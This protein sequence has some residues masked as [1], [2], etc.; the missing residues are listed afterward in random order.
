[1]IY[2]KTQSA[3]EAK[4]LLSLALK[5]MKRK[6]IRLL[7]AGCG[8]NW[9]KKNAPKTVKVTGLDINNLSA[10][11]QADLEK[12]LPIKNE[13]Y[14]VIICTSVIE[15]LKNPI[16]TFKEF[17]RIL[18]KEGILLIT[19]PSPWDICAWDDPYHYKPYTLNAWEMLG[20]DATLKKVEG[21]YINLTPLFGI[22]GLY[23]LRSF[24]LWWRYKAKFL[25]NLKSLRGTAVM[26]YRK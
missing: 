19:T 4:I 6:P 13:S 15:H 25:N 20:H 1:M 5:N 24:Y 18:K 12:K 9:I 21:F 7:D 14:D 23:K 22:L 3:Q 2:D 26:L 10:D 17:Q 16:N 8:A 11:I